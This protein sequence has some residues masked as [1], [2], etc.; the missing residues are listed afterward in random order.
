MPLARLE[1][2]TK[3]TTI[4]E[5]NV[6]GTKV[7]KEWSFRTKKFKEKLY[8]INTNKSTLKVKAGST[9]ILYMVP[10]NRRDILKGYSVRGDIK[11]TFL[12]QNTLRV[13]LPKRRTSKKMYLKFG[14]Y[15]K[16]SFI[17]E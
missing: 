5:A 7:K 8:R 6:D 9:I 12:D 15:K 1:F 17:I 3:Y 4:F 2:N 10:N 11:A 16:V 14:K 13:T